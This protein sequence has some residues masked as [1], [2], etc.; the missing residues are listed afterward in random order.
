MSDSEAVER[1]HTRDCLRTQ[2]AGAFGTGIALLRLVAELFPSEPSECLAEL[3]TEA[4]ATKRFQ[5]NCAREP[6]MSKVR[7]GIKSM[8]ALQKIAFAR[9]IIV[10]MTNNPNFPAPS[11]DLGTMSGVAVAL[12]SAYAAAQSARQTA[13]T[14]TA[15]QKMKEAALERAISQQANYVDSASG[16]DKAKIE[17]SGFAARSESSPVGLP[18][19]PQELMVRNGELPGTVA[20]KWKPVRGARSYVIEFA[21]ASGTPTAWMQLAITSKARHASNGLI[22]GTRYW[23]RVAAV[24]SA[25]PGPWSDPAQ[26][27]AA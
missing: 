16:G 1:A 2:G 27:I 6:Y 19:I 4:R 22:S 13:K 21:A 26:R 24:G 25:G 12:E 11:P 5:L 10:E 9:R 7:V 17:S 18:S 14:L 20:L 8:T 15:A 3:R 23:F